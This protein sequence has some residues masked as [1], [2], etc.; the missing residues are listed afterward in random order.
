MREGSREG[1]P[2]SLC[3]K[4]L[5]RRDVAVVESSATLGDL[6][7]SFS[8]AKVS[9]FP[10]LENGR[11]VGVISRADVVNQLA[12]DQNG[13]STFYAEIGTLDSGDVLATFDEIASRAGK[14]GEQMSIAELMTHAI[15]SVAPD[16][17]L[18]QVART[19]MEHRVH[20]VLVVDGGQ[21]VG[22]VSS[23]DL[24]RLVAEARLQ[25]AG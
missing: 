19:I 17:S 1:T 24:V 22:I 13:A 25:I 5:M 20:R 7:R 12:H 4:D 23:L 3:A 15:V 9:G 8:E 11:V 14:T 6:E 10:V 18:Q 2:V 16:D 21:L